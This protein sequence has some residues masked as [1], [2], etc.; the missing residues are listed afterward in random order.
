MA[1][2]I[3]VSLIAVLSIPG[4]L[5][6]A[7]LRPLPSPPAAPQDG[8][9]RARPKVSVVVPARNEERSLPRLLR[10]LQG[11]SLRPHEV[12]VADDGS[13]D[14]TA[15]AAVDYGARVLPVPDRPSG[16]TGKNWACWNGATV[17]SGRML[18]FLDADVRLAPHALTRLARAWESRG[19]LVS[20]QPYHVMERFWER[21]SAFFNIVVLASL[22][23]FSLIG[24]GRP[25]GAYGPC[26]AVG[27]KEYMRLRGHE[28]VRGEVLEDVALARRFAAAKQP[29]TNFVGTD[30]VRFRM[31]PDGVGQLIEGWSKNMA[32]GAFMT[33]PATLALLI[34]WFSGIAGA[35]FRLPV[36]VAA[37]PAFTLSWW[38][39]LGVYGLYTVQLAWILSRIGTFTL[40]SALVFPLHFTFFVAVFCI[41]LFQLMVL[42]KVRWK[43]RSIDVPH[44]SNP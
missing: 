19:G 17:A 16:W 36:V 29:V 35:A 4:W 5:L 8:A 15:A 2:V 25:T 22:D 30:T 9:G 31:Y 12:I 44:R 42:R 27:R 34:L 1:S 41:S 33:R 28:S 38:P 24:G 13:T 37:G 23:S 32:G 11:Q 39:A 6:F 3:V 14:G 40:L 20:V 21:L 18:L 10:S 26:L 7:R 43:G